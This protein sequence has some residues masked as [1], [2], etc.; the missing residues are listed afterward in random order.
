MIV[1]TSLSPASL[2]LIYIPVVNWANQP[3]DCV[4]QNILHNLFLT[5]KQALFIHMV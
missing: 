4:I 3:F 5:W 1:E 2:V